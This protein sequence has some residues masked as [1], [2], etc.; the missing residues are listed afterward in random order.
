MVAVYVT[1][2]PICVLALAGAKVSFVA[3]PALTVKA[4]LAPASP[5]AETLTVAFPAAVIVKLETATPLLAVTG[6]AGL[7]LP[8]SPLTAKLTAFVAVPTT[9][10]YAS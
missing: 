1:A 9:L 6:E 7:K 5:V 3:E 10:P 2:T 8:D 4:A